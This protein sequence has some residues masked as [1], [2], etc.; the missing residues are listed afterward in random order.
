M[1]VEV[2]P[3]LVVP[4]QYGYPFLTA[5]VIAIIGWVANRALKNRPGAP[6]VTE[7]WEETR[8]VRTELN[9]FRGAVDV[10]FHWMERA[11]ADWNTGKPIPRLTQREREVL[12]KIRPLPDEVLTETGPTLAPV[13]EM[14]RAERP[15][16]RKEKP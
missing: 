15:R 4:P 1:I 8:L 7:A 6:T 10:F 11:I 5:V 16:K 14:S 13:P 3:D 12:D 9:D 2:I